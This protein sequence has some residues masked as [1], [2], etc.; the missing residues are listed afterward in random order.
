MLYPWRRRWHAALVKVF[1]A[2]PESKLLL[3]LNSSNLHGWAINFRSWRRVRF[4]ELNKVLEQVHFNDHIS[5][6]T[7]S[8]SPILH[9]CCVL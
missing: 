5:V 7:G 6:T 3:V 9:G 4:L 8:N 2:C 1:G